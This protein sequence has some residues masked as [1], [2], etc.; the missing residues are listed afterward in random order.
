MPQAGVACAVALPCSHVVVHNTI[1][2]SVGRVISFSPSPL[3]DELPTR[4]PSPF[5][6]AAVHPLAHR[7]AQEMLVWLASPAAAAWRLNA[8]GNGKMFG[9]LVVQS[10]DG[11]VG[12]LRGFS[13]MVDGEWDLPGWVPPLFDRVARDAVWLAGDA[14]MRAL[15]A[16]RAS[17]ERELGDGDAVLALR[18]LDDIRSARSRQLLPLIQ[19]TYHLPNVLGEVRTLREIFS[20]ALPPG[21]AGDCA[22]PKLLAEAYRRGLRPLALAEVWFGAAPRSGDRRSGSFYPACHGKCGPILAHMLC[23]LPADAPPVF[24]ASSIAAN[25]PAVLYEDTHLLIVDKPAGLLSVPGRSGLLQDCVAT[26]LRARYPDATGQMVVHRLDLDTSGLLLAAKDPLTFSA[27]Q[28]LFALREVTK[29]YVAVVAGDVN[30]DAGLIDLP[31]RT[32]ID[33]RPRQ[34]H[35]PVHGK[36]AVTSWQVLERRD[37]RTRLSLTPH[38]GRTHQLRVHTAHP[39][40]LD[41]PICGDRLYGRVAPD[42]GERLQLHAAHLSFVHPATGLTHNVDSAVPF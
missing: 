34:I 17:L 28:R 5:D 3:D 11:M 36:S 20:P 10:P 27:L 33:D 26:R 15:S 8:P 31:L 2:V 25:E 21:G 41:A 42:H 1:P 13:G 35:D 39:L 14:E 40:G 38:T 16:D 9:V 24:G 30:G 18:A 29:R 19:D 4:F 23:G 12:Y 37:G 32:D 6:R 22:A 7:A